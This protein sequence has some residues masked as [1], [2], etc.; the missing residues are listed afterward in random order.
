MIDNCDAY[1]DIA[2]KISNAEA[3][4]FLGAGASLTSSRS[5]GNSLPTG[6]QLKHLIAKCMSLNIDKDD[7]LADIVAVAAQR[8]EELSRIFEQQFKGCTP[9]EEYKIIRTYPWKRIYTLNIDDSFENTGD[10]SPGYSQGLRVTQRND[11]LPSKESLESVCYVKLNGDINFPDNGYIFTPEDYGEESANASNW[12]DEVGRDFARNTFIFIG[13]Q[14]DEPTFQHMVQRYKNKISGPYSRSYL[15]VPNISD[16]KKRRFE[17][18]NIYIIK[19]NLTEFIN[20]LLKRIPDGLSASSVIDKKYPWLTKK[21][22]ST[23]DIEILSEISII[24]PETLKGHNVPDHQFR[25]FY[26]GFKPTWEDIIDQV[27]AQLNFLK[28]IMEYANSAKPGKLIVLKGNA[29]S[30]KTTTLMQTAI[31]ISKTYRAYYLKYSSD[32]KKAVRLINEIEP[33]NYY[34]FIERISPFINEIRDLQNSKTLSR[35]IIVSAERS[36]VWESRIVE[37]L[38][39]DSYVL[40]DVSRIEREDAARILTKL[41]QFGDFS[42]LRKMPEKKRINEIYQK[43]SGQLLIGLLEATTGEGYQNLIRKDYHN[44]S[45]DSERHLVALIALATAN[46]SRSAGETISIAMQDLGFD[47]NLGNYYLSLKGIVVKNKNY[48]EL[49]H[50]V[51]A[52]TILKNI[53][54]KNKLTNVILA[55]LK[56]FSHFTPPV[57]SGLSRSEQLVF[58]A[59]I[60]AKYL[61]SLL[62]TKHRVLSVYK[63]CEKLYEQDGLFWLQYARALRMHKDHEGAF[64]KLKIAKEVWGSSAQIMHALAQQKMIMVLL[65][66][67]PNPLEMM[68]EAVGEFR[69]LESMEKIVKAYPIVTLAECHVRGA[70][71]HEGVDTALGL[72]SKYHREIGQYMKKHP[73]NSRLKESSEKLMRF[74]TTKDIDSIKP[75]FDD[76]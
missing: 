9:S 7:S 46:S 6:N 45:E 54:D 28:P 49:R 65:K 68:S 15:V 27:P 19:N 21:G 10:K 61:S 48:F 51:Y 56:A 62:V 12:Y 29:G 24:S 8:P 55:Y 67:V 31:S 73:E 32:L 42:R 3:I 59:L 30:G 23:R 63:Y 38:E 13:T 1:K 72:A 17:S 40:F 57:V 16:A 36:G 43:T 58:K 66:K 60:N 69:Q 34:I 75:D 4:L 41:E 18:E 64:K 26:E 20:E 52:E 33:G 25:E 50:S 14:L 11:Y 71:L 53:V 2:N 74:Y 44:L 37:H 70:F 35:V 76:I 39:E 47:K 22:L 5:D